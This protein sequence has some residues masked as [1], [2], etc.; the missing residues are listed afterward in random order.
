MK[1]KTLIARSGLA[2]AVLA[3]SSFGVHAG[4]VSYFATQD[5]P[6]DFAVASPPALSA[7]VSLARS[8][9]NNASTF[10]GRHEFE[11]GL[12]QFDYTG[13]SASITAGNPTV[14]FGNELTDFGLG[15]YNMTTSLLCLDPNGACTPNRGRWLETNASFTYTLTQ[16]VSAIAF[17]GTD[18]G[19]FDGTVSIEFLLGGN[20]V[21]SQ[22]IS[23][24]NSAIN[25][26]LIFFGAV[27][28]TSAD[29]FDSFRFNVSNPGSADFL[30]IDSL[31]LANS[32][33]MAP[34]PGTVPIPSS[35]ALAGLGLAL[36]ARFRRRSH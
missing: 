36:M 21:F 34:P 33:V 24:T 6:S 27:G 13:G 12:R 10:L 4:F 2:C 28:Q 23:G 8:N 19:D 5:P 35:L 1:N 29:R 7:S 17:F 30:G 11:N 20:S 9:F 16:A 32:N 22:S 14:I 15:R 26:N 18:F 31:V 3:L 25:G